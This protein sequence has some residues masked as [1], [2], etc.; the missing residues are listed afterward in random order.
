MKENRKPVALITSMRLPCCCLLVASLLV[1]LAST[2]LSDSKS[3]FDKHKAEIMKEPSLVRYY[4]FEEGY[5]EEVWNWVNFSPGQQALTGGPLGSLLILRNC[6]YNIDR[7]SDWFHPVT[8]SDP[9]WTVG[10]WPWKAALTNGFNGLNGLNVFHSE[11]RG[12]EFQPGFAVEAWI[13]VH[14]YDGTNKNCLLLNI[15]GGGKDGFTINH[16]HALDSKGSITFKVGGV[17]SVAAGPFTPGVWHHLV[18]E[19]D[20]EA[21][22]VFID[23]ELRGEKA[24][25]GQYVAPPSKRMDRFKTS[26]IDEAQRATNLEIGGRPKSGKARF[27][28]CELA[29]YKAALP[30]ETIKRNYLS[31]KPEEAPDRQ[32]AAFREL[33]G[34]TEKARKIAIEV[35]KDTWGFFAIGTEIPA[36]ITFPEDS[37]FKGAFQAELELTG[38]G[39]S[40]VLERKATI[41]VEG[42]KQVSDTVKIPAEKPGIYFLDVIVK[43]ADGKIVKR[44]PEKFCLGFTVPPVPATELSPLNPLTSRGSYGA[45]NEPTK[46]QNRWLPR[47]TPFLQTQSYIP[48]GVSRTS[49]DVN[50]AKNFMDIGPKFPPLLH[51]LYFGAYQDKKIGPAD[52]KDIRE[53]VTAIVKQLKPYVYAWEIGS[54]LN[55][56]VTAE[57]FM[58]ILKICSEVI[59]KEAPGTK[60]VASGASPS[61]E[62]FTNRILELGAA[63]YIDVL[64]YHNYNGTPIHWHRWTNV[65]G[66]LKEMIKKHS[67][68]P[69]EIWNTESGIISLSRRG[70][71]PMTK[72]DATRVGLPV[73]L[74]PKNKMFHATSMPVYEE[75]SAAAVEVQAILMDLSEGFKKYVKCHTSSAGLNISDN[76]IGLP[77]LQGVAFT[78]LST[79]VNKMAK[80]EE[81]PLSSLDDACVIVTDTAGK[82]TAVAFSDETPTL[83]FKA[84]A[85]KTYRGMDM[86][87][88]PLEWKTGDDGLMLVKLGEDPVYIFDVPESFKQISPLK[89]SCPAKLPEEGTLKGTLVVN[90]PF[91]TE[92]RAKLSAD[93]LK[94][95]DIIIDKPDVILAP[96]AES[97]V[98][99]TLQGTSLKRR[100]YGL[101]FKLEDG[102]KLIAAT[103][104]VFDSQGVVTSIMETST[105]IVLDGDE[106]EWKNIPADTVD[107]VDSVVSGMPNMAELWLPQW[108]GADDLSFTVQYAWRKNDGIYILLKVKDSVVM[109]AAKEQ[110]SMAFNWDCLELF[111]DSRPQGERGGPVGIGADQAI[112]IPKVGDKAEKC[113]VWF[114]SVGRGERQSMINAEFVGRK[115]K[116]GYLLEG[117]ITPN[118]GSSLKILAGSQFCMDFI[119][120][121]TDTPKELLS[122]SMALH[123]IRQNYVNSSHWGRY[124]LDPKGVE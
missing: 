15:N 5:G 50:Y 65:G 44:I 46:N 76:S 42:S 87:G 124:R 98:N 123:G 49:M 102:G 88:N 35:P 62:P 75:R 68:K 67:Q 108:R 120:D 93:S 69:L 80:V 84:D 11:L 19:Y 32:L 70:E 8:E 81:L 23:G 99:F 28:I 3:D 4:T 74:T 25:K 2:V 17:D 22:K 86:I 103:S 114:S 48:N 10:R 54:E 90:N 52:E 109:P 64:S 96:G 12:D 107:T 38:L 115:T 55:G 16:T 91:K 58:K 89:V 60:I 106:S 83:S 39:G 21:L 122:S 113:V 119:I 66:K 111:F 47:M 13:R 7:Q 100:L 94:G 34:Q 18:C 56:K 78:T 71:K 97:T 57:E 9:E 116:D 92:L 36:T 43:N 40:K 51:M 121:D 72:E 45:W 59:R 24:K 31:G 104:A 37:G 61:G 101:R 14:E 79:V 30:T 29:V 63:E 20:G 73:Y 53:S 26:Q 105:P 1:T 118:E 82:R 95:A 33:R 85:G 112:V 110:E 27:D 6:P 41:N 117:K 77:T